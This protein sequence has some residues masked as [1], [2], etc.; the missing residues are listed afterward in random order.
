[1]KQIKLKHMPEFWS[2]LHTIYFKYLTGDWQSMAVISRETGHNF[3]SAIWDLCAWGFAEN[4]YMEGAN[5]RAAA[6]KNDFRLKPGIIEDKE[7]YLKQI[8]ERK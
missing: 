2:E 1:M 6:K 3:P 5:R 7:L 4:V 8:T